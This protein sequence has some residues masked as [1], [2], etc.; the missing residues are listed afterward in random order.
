MVFNGSLDVVG[1]A[2]W[3]SGYC[4]PALEQPSRLILDNAPI[5]QK[6]VILPTTVGLQDLVEVAGHQ[7]LFLLK[8][9]PDCFARPLV[10]NKIKHDFSA[11]KQARM[12]AEPGTSID[13]IIRNYCTA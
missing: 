7:V 5:H 2:R 12:Y 1:F 6:A 13:E 11:L 9:S 3:L 8:Y 4:L 10:Y